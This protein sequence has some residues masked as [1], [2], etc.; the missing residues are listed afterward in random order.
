MPASWSVKKRDKFRGTPHRQKPDLD[1]LTKAL[2]DAALP[3]TDA[4]IWSLSAF[5]VWADE[6]SIEVSLENPF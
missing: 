5:K 3:K 6:G 1:N 4:E 2:L